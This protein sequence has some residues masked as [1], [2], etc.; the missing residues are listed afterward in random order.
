MARF[1]EITVGQVAELEHTV[2]QKDLERFVELSGDDNRLHVDAEYAARTSFKK[3]VAHGML[4]VSFIST[5]IG[6]RL[7]GDGAL[8]FSQNLEFLLPVRVG[9]KLTVRAEVLRK[10]DQ[11]KA[12]ELQTEILNQHGQ[13]VTTGVAKVKVIEQEAEPGAEPEPPRPVALVVG[14]SGGIGSAVC[15]ELAANGFDVAVHGLNNVGRA[16][17]IARAVEETGQKALVIAAD[18]RDE[19]EVEDMIRQVKRHLGAITVVVNCTTAPMI[20]VKWT[21]VAWRDFDAHFQTALKGAL[22]LVKH[23][24]PLMEAVGYGKI[25]HVSAQTIDAPMGN[26]LPF[27]T[28]KSALKGFS[29]ALAIELASK[30]IRVNM[31]A[32]GMT[33]T[34]QLAD[35]PERVRLMA[36]SRTPLRRLARPEDIAG[37]VAFL[38]SS[39]SDFMTGETVRVN[40]GQAMS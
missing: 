7:P 24:T 30:G 1:D 19:A 22:Y 38:A 35:I 17:T 2:T 34:D 40:G 27:I 31:V 15:R 39:Q 20:P 18:I 33:D 3:P 13:K 5:I 28:A 14:G 23:V 12:I 6:T 36:A 4:G 37:V 21:D 8:W 9:D 11:M 32:P 26:M 25:I 29:K 10:I 16:E